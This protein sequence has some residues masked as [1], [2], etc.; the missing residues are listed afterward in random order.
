MSPTIK[1]G[2]LVRHRLH[3]RLHQHDIDHGGLVDNQ[4][5]AVER[6]VVAALEAAALG[7]DLEQPVDGLGLEAGRLGHALGGAAGRSAQQKLHCPSPRGCAEW[8]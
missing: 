5:V 2:G 8:H 4:Q 7:I 1:Q 6:V 3:E